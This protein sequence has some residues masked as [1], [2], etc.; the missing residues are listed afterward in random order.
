MRLEWVRSDRNGDRR[1]VI[2][3]AETIEDPEA[4]VSG[5]AADPTCEL[6]RVTGGNGRRLY[7]VQLQEEST[8]DVYS[9]I[10]ETG[11]V[12]EQA[13]VD[14]EGWHCRFVF[15]DESALEWFFDECREQ[16]LDFEVH[17][18]SRSAD[19]DVESVLTDPQWRALATAQQLGY[20]EIPRQGSITDVADK[21]DISP[22]AASQRLR[23]GLGRL[24]ER[25]LGS[26]SDS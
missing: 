26:E 10:I 20:F 15:P 22:T 21:L 5:I 23:R 3:W 14:C 4:L 8:I 2:L 18:L 13:T 17:R 7:E 1:K 19:S 12:V 11:A 6:E 25:E 16:G 9:A 24:V